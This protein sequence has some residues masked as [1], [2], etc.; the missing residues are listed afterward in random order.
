MT[1]YILDASVVVNLLLGKENRA[2]AAV[3]RILKEAEKGKTKTYSSPLLI[4][5][6]GNSL[7]YAL[8]DS[9]I[10]DEPFQ[11]F[12]DLPISYFEFEQGHHLQILKQS[13]SLKTSFYDTS[14][15][16]L[17]QLLDGTFLTA[18]EDYFKKAKNLGHIEL[19]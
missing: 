17:A 4:F 16:F 14:Y 13:Y 15:H 18:D 19:V 7:R 8:T 12:L 2:A 3:K 10:A 5:E 9:L 1:A 6:V 11:Q